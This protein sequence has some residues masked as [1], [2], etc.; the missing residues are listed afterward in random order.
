MLSFLYHFPFPD[1]QRELDR[2]F[3]RNVDCDVTLSSYNT[4]G[5]HRVHKKFEM[6]QR[7]DKNLEMKMKNENEAKL[8]ILQTRIESRYGMGPRRLPHE[9][10]VR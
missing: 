5:H 1:R 3:T 2:V 9:E 8:R 4:Q 7:I 6:E 10:Q